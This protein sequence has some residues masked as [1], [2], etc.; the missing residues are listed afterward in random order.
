[1]ELGTAV[2]GFP[3]GTYDIPR[4]VE[5]FIVE[6]NEMMEVAVDARGL[7]WLGKEGP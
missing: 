6:N 1:M 4:I 3:N 7:Q 5:N 2:G